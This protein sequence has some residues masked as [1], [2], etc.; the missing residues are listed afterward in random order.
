MTHHFISIRSSV[1]ISASTNISGLKGNSETNSQSID[2]RLYQSKIVRDYSIQ[3]KTTRE[4]DLFRNKL[5]NWRL[6]L[7]SWLFYQKNNV[8]SLFIRLF[9]GSFQLLSCTILHHIYLLFQRLVIHAEFAF[10]HNSYV[11]L[12]YKNILSEWEKNHHLHCCRKK[13]EGNP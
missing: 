8:Q 2:S 7:R 9:T 1:Y 4:I 5:E 3:Q 12:S 11:L 13:N 10:V 6:H